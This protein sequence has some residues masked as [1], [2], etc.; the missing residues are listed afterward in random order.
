MKR[1]KLT[2]EEKKSLA[3]EEIRRIA[4]LIGKTPTKNEYKEFNDVKIAYGQIVYVYKSWNAAITDAGLKV[5]QYRLPN[6]SEIPKEVLV[7]E[8][9]RVA[10][11]VGHMPVFRIF[12]QHST[13]SLTPFLRQ[14]K[15]WNLTKQY[16]YSHYRNRLTFL[17][18]LILPRRRNP[19]K[20]K[21]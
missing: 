6:T 14:F 3:K 12:S 7:D 5:N 9:I 20:R 10:N 16:I 21:I 15:T 13:M 4:K 19:Y 17:P 1:K 18:P 8:F 11:I 2:I